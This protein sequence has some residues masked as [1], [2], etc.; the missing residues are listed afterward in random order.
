VIIVA[1]LA[2]LTA[3]G[4]GSERFSSPQNAG[5]PVV[6]AAG[7]TTS[8]ASEGDEATA[9]LLSG[10]EGTVVTLGDHAYPDGS[11]EDFGERLG[12]SNPHRSLRRPRG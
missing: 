4:C 3:V 7:D 2:T 1:I 9:D 6:I 5:P 11:V 10:F 12:A 8:C